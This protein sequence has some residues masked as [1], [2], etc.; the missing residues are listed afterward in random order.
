MR[1]L[2][3]YPNILM[4]NRIPLGIAYLSSILKQLGHQVSLFDTTFYK[5]ADETDD[6]LR[7]KT[8][9][10]KET[11]L[12]QYGVTWQ[13]GSYERDF[14]E[15]LMW[16]KPDQVWYSVAENTYPVAKKLLRLARQEGF[17]NVVGGVLPTVAGDELSQNTDIDRVFR[18]EA[19]YACDDILHCIEKEYPL[20]D[21]ENLPFQ[22][23]S[24][25]SE[26]HIWRPLGGKV[27]RTGNFMMSRGCPYACGF[28]INESQVKKYGGKYH[29]EMGINRALDE[30]VHFKKVYN[31][32]LINFHDETFLL[33]PRRR[34]EYFC[35]EYK[36]RVDLPYSILTRVETINDERMKLLVDSG[37]INMSM[38]IECGN[39]EIRRNVLKRKMSN[40]C[41]VNAFRTAKK[42]PVRVSTS[43]MI[44]IPGEGRKEIFE[45]IALNKECSPDSST[46][47]MLY[48]YRGSSVRELCL[49]KGYLDENEIGGGVR[50]G[51]ILNLP[52][53]TK[54][55]LLG[56]QRCFQF[57][58]RYPESMYTTIK[59]AETNDNAFDVMTN[60]YCGDFPNA[61]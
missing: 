29:R 61:G 20:F 43:N 3:V 44:G 56:I 8:L 11:D 53:I 19:E 58:M 42:Y 45:T 57:Y 12:S 30:I 18:G 22:D 52:D 15:K 51:S 39:P 26:K 36:K 55:E 34:L 46:V 9:Q 49:E 37:C 1:I 21:I 10:V 17:Y 16:Y 7:H 25:F 48:P 54:E 47:N 40:E 33:M 23:W 35:N 13:E 60:L 5:S 38:S 14:L 31:L 28:C 50:G 2:F 27:Y 59:D 6:E 24:L 32:E 4:V 41:I